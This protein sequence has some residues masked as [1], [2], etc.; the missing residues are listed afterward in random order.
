MEATSKTIVK[1]TIFLYVRMFLVLG[2]SLYASRVILDAL[3]IADY[4]IYSAVSGVALMITFFTSA[5]SNA[6]QRFISFELG[7]NDLKSARD[8]FSMMVLIFSFFILILLIIL[9]TGGLWIVNNKLVIPAERFVAAQWVYQL[10]VISCILVVA[11]VPYIS[12]IIAEEKM[13]IYAFIGLFDASVKLVIIFLLKTSSADKLILYSL[14]YCFA[15]FITTL[16]Y[17]VFCNIKFTESHLYYYWE[18]SKAKAF[19]SFIGQ[20]IFGCF[21][22]SVAYEGSSIALNIFFGPLVNAARGVAK[23]VNNA[24]NV[25][26]NGISTAFQPQIVKSYS[27]GDYAIFEKLIIQCSK[28]TALLFLIISLP[29][30]LNIDAILSIWLVK[31]P[32][33]SKE[34]TC[35]MIADSIIAT[36]MLP[37][38]TAL[39]ATGKIKGLQVYGRAITLAALPVS[40]L[41]LKYSVFSSPV[42]PLVVLVIAEFVYWIYCFNDLNRKTGIRYKD[43]FFMSILPLSLLAILTVVI[44]RFCI[45]FKSES[46]FSTA[47]RVFSE[48]GVMLTLSFLFVLNREERRFFVNRLKNSLSRNRSDTQ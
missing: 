35:L 3:G 4:G 18:K 6:S 38:G 13:G 23:Q 27:S 24:L 1:N 47:L 2:I 41:L 26:V 8:V 11:Q 15:Q 5:L 36:Q 43:Y 39:N 42:V 9:E 30:L 12:C 17:I 46:I 7:K 45:T 22:Y 16:I 19:F 31:V 25:F 44:D 21:A 37:I 28:Y 29:V 14:L 32:E 34:F 48:L 40:Y 20:S 33:Y 10:S